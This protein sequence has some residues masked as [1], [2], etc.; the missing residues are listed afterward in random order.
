M[1]D[2]PAYIFTRKLTNDKL[3]RCHSSCSRS[4]SRR[5]WRECHAT[6]DNLRNENVNQQILSFFLFCFA[7]LWGITCVY[8]KTLEIK[9]PI[10]RLSVLTQR[11]AE[12]GLLIWFVVVFLL[13][14]DVVG[15]WRTCYS[16]GDV[17]MLE[18]ERKNFVMI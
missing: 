17:D 16:G 14:L 12:L 4:D 7:L 5:K 6:R 10:L 2:Y 9:C 15:F 11:R 1:S 8:V 18:L 13:S 3:P